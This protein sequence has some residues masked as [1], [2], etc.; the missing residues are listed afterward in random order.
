MH[1]TLDCTAP[2]SFRQLKEPTDIEGLDE[3]VTANEETLVDHGMKLMQKKEYIDNLAAEIG[4]DP[5]TGEGLMDGGMSRIDY[6]AMGIV[7]NASGAT[8]A[9]A[10]VGFQF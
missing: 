6:N 7:T 2:A 10:G 4:I 3:R 8:G 9:S 1:S 5:V